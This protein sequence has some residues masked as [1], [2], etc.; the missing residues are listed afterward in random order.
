MVTLENEECYCMK[1]A[2]YF[3]IGTNFQGE[4]F[5]LVAIAKG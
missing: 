4:N 1:F 5:D 3:Y 2:P